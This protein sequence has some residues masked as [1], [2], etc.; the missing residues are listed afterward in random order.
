MMQ[1]YGDS[2]SVTFLLADDLHTPSFSDFRVRVNQ[3]Q[4]QMDGANPA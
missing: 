2:E 4:M 3:W 1:T